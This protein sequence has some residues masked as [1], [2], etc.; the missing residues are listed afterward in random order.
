MLR[1]INREW[2]EFVEHSLFWFDGKLII[3]A[4]RLYLEIADLHASETQDAFV[5]QIDEE[6]YSIPQDQFRF[7]VVQ[8]SYSIIRTQNRYD[9]AAGICSKFLRK[10]RQANDAWNFYMEW[11][12]F[13]KKWKTISEQW[14]SSVQFIFLCFLSFSLL[15]LSVY[16]LSD[17]NYS[18]NL[19]ISQIFG[20]TFI[21][22]TSL[23]YSGSLALHIL[24]KLCFGYLLRFGDISARLWLTSR[25]SMLLYSLATLISGTISFAVLQL[26]LSSQNS[27]KNFIFVSLPMWFLQGITGLIAVRYLGSNYI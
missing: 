4:P 6:I 22:L 20:F 11:A 21:Y 16:I 23:F 2:K 19:S 27:D 25:E 18:D 24:G 5:I 14:L 12:P 26:T 17:I 1:T 15:V 3:S 10:L 7:R 8:D 9:E 13:C